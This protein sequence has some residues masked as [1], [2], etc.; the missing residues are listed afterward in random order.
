MLEKPIRFLYLAIVLFVVSIGSILLIQLQEAFTFGMNREFD[1]TASRTTTYLVFADDN[2]P[3]YYISIGHE[4]EQNDICG[5]PMYP[6]TGDTNYCYAFYAIHE[7]DEDYFYIEP[8]EEDLGLTFQEHDYL[9][10]ITLQKG[11]TSIRVEPIG[12]LSSQDVSDF[13]FLLIPTNLI[14][15]TVLS[16]SFGIGSVGTLSIFL[17]FHFKSK[18]R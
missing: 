17:I 2:V 13:S 9:G 12:G 7:T 1:I 10:T 16:V 11:S 15:L 6:F 3:F 18:R 5:E 4:V 8:P 14:H